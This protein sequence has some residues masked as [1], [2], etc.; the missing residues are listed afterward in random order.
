MSLRYG[1]LGTVHQG[2]TVGSQGDLRG[3]HDE[4]FAVMGE[5]AAV[6]KKDSRGDYV[7]D[8]SRAREASTPVAKLLVDNLARGELGIIEHLQGFGGQWQGQSRS[9]SFYG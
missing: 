3:L 2:R 1:M 4:G 5:T 7:G 9:R 6:S 8:R